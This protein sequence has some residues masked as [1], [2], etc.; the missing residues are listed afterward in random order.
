MIEAPP[1]VFVVDDDPS[2]RDSLSLLLSS[3][4]YD[5]NTFAS[6][7]EYLESERHIPVPD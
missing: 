1:T 3:A 5:V 2:I 7:I 6:A 4:G